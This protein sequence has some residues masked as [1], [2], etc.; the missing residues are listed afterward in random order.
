M[1][2]LGGVG[3]GGNG[4]RRRFLPPFPLPLWLGRWPPAN[5]AE[6]YP[7][8]AS[9]MVFF[10]K[11]PP[12]QRVQGEGRPTRPHSTQNPAAQVSY[13]TVT[14][15]CALGFVLSPI[16]KLV[17]EAG[18]AHQQFDEIHQL[19]RGDVSQLQGWHIGP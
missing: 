9:G 13:R 18:V 16:L 5:A 1:V 17:A 6:P 3:S 12:S 4:H 11:R 14:V 7:V 15:A 2:T 19:R 10:G 8:A